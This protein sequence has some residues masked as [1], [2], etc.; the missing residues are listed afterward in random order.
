MKVLSRLV[1]SAVFALVAGFSFAQPMPMMGGHGPTEMLKHFGLSDDQSKQVA[2]IIDK[3]QSSVVPQ[4]A[5]LKVLN[6]QIELA[7]T[8]SNADLKAIDALVDKK[9]Q[10]QSDM[11]KQFLAG[12]VQ[13]HGIVGD[14]LFAKLSQAYL[15]H[16][17]MGGRGWK[18]QQGDP[19]S[20]PP[21]PANP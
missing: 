7:L 5:Q 6:A 4:R 21:K 14:Q 17:R 8:A 18:H 16:H 11:E 2:D 12:A 15:M 20:M 10:L 13:I 3:E 9:T 1:T 19:G